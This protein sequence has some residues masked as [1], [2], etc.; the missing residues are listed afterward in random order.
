MTDSPVLRELASRAALG[1]A[2]L[3]V[4]ALDPRGAPLWSAALAAERRLYPASMIKLPIAMTLAALCEAGAYRL[5]DGVEVTPENLTTNDAPS[6]FVA[7]YRAELG[8][9]ARAMLSASDNVA[10]NVLIDVLGR[11]TIGAACGALGLRDT[12]VRRK[13][14]GS[15]PLIDDPAA[16]GRNTHPAA[17]AAALLRLLAGPAWSRRPG[18]WVYDALLA[19][20][21]NDKLPRGWAPGDVF[22]HKTG[23]TDEVSHDGGILTARDGRRFIVVAYTNLPSTPDTDARLAEFAALLRPLLDDP[24]TGLASL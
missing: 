24:P 18:S 17:D 15:L 5:E 11:E 1:E 20:I 16:T 10:T 2:S 9:L 7:G 22:A 19:Q 14:S 4:E 8:Q 6:P 3:V 12:A 13:L 21:W 23:D